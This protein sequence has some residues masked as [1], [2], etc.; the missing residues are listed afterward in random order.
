MIALG[1]VTGCHLLNHSHLPPVL[2]LFK[3]FLPLTMEDGITFSQ[4]V[5]LRW[6]NEMAKAIY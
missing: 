1:M 2:N 4:F 3:S 5:S 6:T